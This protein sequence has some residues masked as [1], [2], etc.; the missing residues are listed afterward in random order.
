[1]HH[2]RLPAAAPEAIRTRCHFSDMIVL[3]RTAMDCRTFRRNIRSW[4]EGDVN[5][6]TLASLRAHEASCHDC[7]ELH[8]AHASVRDNVFAYRDERVS[9]FVTDL[10]RWATA[11]RRA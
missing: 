8:E 11:R 2:A 1:M 4:L 6:R 5:G 3:Y 9:A 7:R 10:V